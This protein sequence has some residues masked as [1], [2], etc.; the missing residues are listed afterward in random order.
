M[1]HPVRDVF[2]HR[3][4][5]ETSQRCPL[6]GYLEYDYLGTGMSVDPRQIWFDTGIAVHY[7]LGVLMEGGGH[8]EAIDR[9]LRYYEEESQQT[10]ENLGLRWH[11][12]RILIEGLLWSFIHYALPTFL[13]EYEVLFVEKECLRTRYV[14]VEDSEDT[15]LMRRV[16]V[17]DI[18][19][20]DVI[21]KVKNTSELAIVNWKTINDLTDERKEN[22]AKGLQGFREHFFG[23]G[24]IGNLKAAIQREMESMGRT[25]SEMT[26][27]Q[28]Q[29][30]I[31]DLQRIIDMSAKVG[32]EPI[33]D[34]TQF[35]YLVKGRRVREATLQRNGEEPETGYVET[36]DGLDNGKNQWRQ[37]SILVY[38]WVRQEGEMEESKTPLPKY[39]WAWR[40]QRP[41]MRGFNT[42]GKALYRR[43]LIGVGGLNSEEWVRMLVEKKVF[44]NTIR[45]DIPS[46]L[47]KIIVYDN[48]VYRK[49]P[50]M[51]SLQRQ[52]EVQQMERI[53][54]LVRIE[55]L[56]GESLKA[57]VEVLFPQHLHSCMAPIKCQFHAFCHDGRELDFLTIPTGYVK[58]IPHHHAEAE[59]FKAERV[60]M[61]P[62]YVCNE[63]DAMSALRHKVVELELR[64]DIGSPLPQYEP[65]TEE[66]SPLRHWVSEDGGVTFPDVMEEEG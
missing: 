54:R 23:E 36:Y 42:L 7:G 60:D 53:R 51:Q 26:I 17:H 10:E 56:D 30:Q 28:M 49:L 33:I 9:S 20:P 15:G 66:G 52:L 38:P 65:L 59:S 13:E 57:Q 63:K 25:A 41:G 8:Q 35:V 34:Y 5:M 21:V 45:P 16:K 6:L 44:P 4:G 11:E 39:S 55:N 64:G 62:D 37:D 24:Y 3:S 27:Q 18:A 61:G 58:R 22:H 2:F 19:R 48:P 50:M 31:R 47:S 40:Y 14:V 29:K 43:E 32:E 1:S 46:P 12:Q